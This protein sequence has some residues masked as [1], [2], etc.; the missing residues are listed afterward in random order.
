VG[1]RDVSV[2]LPT[3]EERFVAKWLSNNTLSQETQELL[4]A[5]TAVYRIYFEELHTLR[6]SKFRIA[7]WDAGW[8]QVRNA[9]EDRGVGSDQLA[10]CRAASDALKLKLLPQIYALGFL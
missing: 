6:I 1:D 10:A 5:G 4:E 7:S 3:A 8:W 9:L 2:Q